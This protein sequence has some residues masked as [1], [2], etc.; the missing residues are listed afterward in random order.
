MASSFAF[1]HT[2]AETDRQTDSLGSMILSRQDP[3]QFSRLGKNRCLN[4]PTGMV[5][6][7]G[8]GRAEARAALIALVLS[9]VSAASEERSR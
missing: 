6:I 7:L 9:P 1:I 5:K 3:T 4:P 8:E 2:L